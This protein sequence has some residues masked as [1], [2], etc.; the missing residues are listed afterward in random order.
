MAK[1]S[2]RLSENVYSLVHELLVPLLSMVGAY[3]ILRGKVPQVIEEPL[4]RFGQIS[5]KLHTE[6]MALF[7]KPET[8]I[9]L[10]SADI[11]AEQIRLLSSGWEKEVERLSQLVSQINGANIHLEDDSLDNILNQVLFRA[12]QEFN[13]I[14][15][16]LQIVQAKHLI[17][18][19][20]F[21]DVLHIERENLR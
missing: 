15:S 10:Q 20:G 2:D 4:N 21:F 6:I 17:L 16:H 3:S 8:R 14:V 9:N 19:D 12:L 13:S 11:A 1:K 5:D 18:K 7:R